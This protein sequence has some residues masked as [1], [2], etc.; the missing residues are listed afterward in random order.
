MI[1][2][3]PTRRGLLY[4]GTETGVYVSFDDGANWQP[5]KGKLPTV[6]IH[7][8]V[9]KE[10][11]GDLVLATHGRSFWILDDLGPMR[12]DAVGHGRSG[13]GSGQAAARGALHDQ[14]RLLA[15]RPTRG[16]NYRMPGAL[17]VTYRQRE[18]PRTGD[19]VDDYLDAGKNPPNGALVPYFLEDKPESDISM[20]FL[21][22]DGQEIRTFS[23][24][25]PDDQPAGR[26]AG[27]AAQAEG[28]AHS[29]GSWP[30][31]LRLEPALS[32]RDAR[33]TTTRLPTSWSRAG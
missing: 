7:D 11:E 30:E 1:R 31:P 23:S 15:A 32:G 22:A 16:K 29:Q 18:D 8:L 28:P 6:P 19:K 21:K 9:V 26:A 17:M 20:T 14:Q 5:L 2:E 33:S 3:D 12:R 27:D 10:P 4:A 25:N 13:G 24:Q